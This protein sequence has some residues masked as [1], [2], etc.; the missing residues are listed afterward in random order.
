MPKY[1]AVQHWSGPKRAR[2]QSN[3]QM[4]SGTKGLT[5]AITTF[6]LI[7]IDAIGADVAHRC[8]RGFWRLCNGGT[9]VGFKPR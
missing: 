4:R 3:M 2:M 8:Q 5:D 6:E 9:V 7:R 1:N